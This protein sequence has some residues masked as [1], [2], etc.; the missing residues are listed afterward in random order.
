MSDTARLDLGQTS[1]ELPTLVGSEGEQAVD[2]SKLRGQTG[3]ITLDEGY[4]NTGSVRSG[5]TFIDGEKGI[6]RYRGYSIEDVTRN[7]TFIRT[8]LLLIE[9][10][11]PE[12]RK[13]D[14]FR[15]AVMAATEVHP[16]VLATIA[17][18]A[19]DTPPMAMLSAAIS[20]CAAYEP[21][22]N[23]GGDLIEEG[24][25]LIG[26]IPTIAAAIHRARAGQAVVASDP[27]RPYSENFLRMMFG[28]DVH[29]D[30]AEAFDKILILHADH[31]Q[32]C[33]TSTTRMIASSGADLY[34]ACAGGV[35]ALSGPLHGGANV[36]VLE[37]LE[38]IHKSSLTAADFIGLVKKKEEK[39]F[40]FGHAVYKAYDPRA[41][42]FKGYADKV[43]ET[44]GVEDPLLDIARELE[45]AAL[46]DEYFTSRNL[47][48]NVDFY[49]GIIMRALGIPT[50]L[51]TVMF[52]LGRMPGWIAQ[53]KEVRDT[54]S[55]IYRPRQVYVGPASRPWPQGA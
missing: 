17:S 54:G 45:A 5:I 27:L 4:R 10:D 29:A 25:R 11:L 46:S 19:P 30:V 26:Q 24:A 35:G 12:G 22:L 44:L 39:L 42:V 51:F 6:L 34:A 49:S 53:F 37:Q 2:I 52:A 31:E 3:W 8:A 38:R 32:N 20:L 36:A 13:K 33:S 15:E 14:R 7:T 48:P 23:S 18:M 9:G 50:D 41:Q 28:G 16:K 43:L 40:G 21:A 55:R 1:I 47:F